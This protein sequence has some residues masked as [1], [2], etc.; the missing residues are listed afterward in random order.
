MTLAVKEK[1]AGGMDWEKDRPLSSRVSSS[2]KIETNTPESEKDD[3]I[4][5]QGVVMLL[6]RMD[7]PGG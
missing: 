1:D 5:E 3:A 7:K 4:R 2:F 6:I